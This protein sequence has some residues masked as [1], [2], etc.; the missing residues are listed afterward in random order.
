MGPR[1]ARIRSPAWACGRG[2][3]TRPAWAAGGGGSGGR[4]GLRAQMDQAAGLVC[5]RRRIGRPLGLRAIAA[6][7]AGLGRGRGRTGLPLR[8]ISITTGVVMTAAQ[9]CAGW[10]GE[11]SR[12]MLM[13]LSNPQRAAGRELLSSRLRCA[14][15]D[16]PRARRRSSIRAPAMTVWKAGLNMSEPRSRWVGG[17]CAYCATVGR[18][19]RAGASGIAWA[20]WTRAVAA[21]A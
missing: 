18:G 14:W 2:W 3:V 16:L 8:Q 12:R 15:I 1:S 17:W 9:F 10:V 13:P 7:A 19:H 4:L 20:L 11:T 6:Q 5:G 21:Y